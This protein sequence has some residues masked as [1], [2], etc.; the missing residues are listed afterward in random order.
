MSD[1][2][3]DQPMEDA[4]PADAPP[5][6]SPADVILQRAQR[7]SRGV[8]REAEA[9]EQRWASLGGGSALGDGTNEAAAPAPAAP[10]LETLDVRVT[11]FAD[12]FTVEEQKP[13]ETKPEP[14]KPR[15][16]GTATLQDFAAPPRPPTL[17]T[18]FPELRPFDSDE[19]R[20]FL[21][22]LARDE[23]P[24][25]LRRPNRRV[26]FGV[27]DARPMPCPWGPRRRRARPC[28][29]R[30]AG[31]AAAPAPEKFTGR[32]RR[33]AALLQR[34]PSRMLRS[35]TRPS[36][37]PPNRWPSSACAS[38]KA[39]AVELNQ[40][41]TVGHLR[42]FVAAQGAG[43]APYDL[44]AGFPPKPQWTRRS[45]SA[46]PGWVVV[47]CP[48]SSGPRFRF[49]APPLLVVFASSRSSSSLDASP[50]VASSRP[51]RR[52]RLDGFA[53]TES[54]PRACA[55]ALNPRDWMVRHRA[56]AAR[57]VPRPR[58]SSRPRGDRRAWHR[59]LVERLRVIHLSLKRETMISPRT[60]R[61]TGSVLR[62]NVLASSKRFSSPRDVA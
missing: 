49:L 50:G 48:R 11:F 40:E 21:D 10:Q 9:A 13:K 27:A 51:R 55:G 52:H 43:G 37:T 18:D 25:S 8:D 59:V 5:P 16:G 54:A 4:P 57:S 38:G 7:N 62:S 29:A 20:E 36:S 41:H 1:Q 30:W 3:P 33:S 46:T 45:R 17:P 60:R 42:A 26:R 14:P 23:V 47:P 12:G 61:A 22:H 24:P 15:R 39:L 34:R 19:S 58:A 56:R 28:S 44:L 35:P 53:G 32:A 2:P 31:G 6:P